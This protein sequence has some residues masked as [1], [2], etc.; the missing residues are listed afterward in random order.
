MIKDAP[1]Q[2]G[3]Q[4]DFLLA[5]VAKE[6]NVKPALRTASVPIALFLSTPLYLQ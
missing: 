1:V 3:T 2:A 6:G 4:K 5:S